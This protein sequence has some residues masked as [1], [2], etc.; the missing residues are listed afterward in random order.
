MLVGRAEATV[1][2]GADYAVLYHVCQTRPYSLSRY[3]GNGFCALSLLNT[4]DCWMIAVLLAGLSCLLLTY[5]VVSGAARMRYV[6]AFLIKHQTL[7]FV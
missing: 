2:R 6:E 3:S 1:G 4:Y 7:N 5:Q